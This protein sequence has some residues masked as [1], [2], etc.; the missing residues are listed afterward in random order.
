MSVSSGS[1]RFALINDLATTHGEV[2]LLNDGAGT[3]L[4]QP[5]MATALRRGEEATRWLSSL[6]EAHFYTRPRVYRGALEDVRPV[7][8]C[9]DIAFF[10]RVGYFSP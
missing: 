10:R 3:V 2:I 4:P 8:S 7:L 9:A 6:Q 5:D 1:E